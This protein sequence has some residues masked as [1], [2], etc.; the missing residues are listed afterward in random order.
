MKNLS[1]STILWLWSEL[2][3]CL[4]LNGHYGSQTAEIY[5]YRLLPFCPRA[6]HSTDIEDADAEQAAKSLYEVLREFAERRNARIKV[7]GV[8]LSKRII[9]PGNKHRWHI[10]V[11][12]P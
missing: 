12:K 1:L 3:D 9:H 10:E 7:D 2:D 6:L 4:Y 11:I 5:V 8:W